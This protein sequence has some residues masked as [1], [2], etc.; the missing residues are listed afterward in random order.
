M[1]TVLE[2]F[3]IECRKELDSYFELGLVLVLL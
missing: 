1:N 3:S 2:Q